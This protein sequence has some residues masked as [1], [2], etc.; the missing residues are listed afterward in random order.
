MQEDQI[1][2]ARWLSCSAVCNGIGPQ[3]HGHQL[4]RLL[5]AELEWDDD[6]NPLALLVFESE[7]GQPKAASAD[8]GCHLLLIRGNSAQAM[9]RAR[10][11]WKG[12]GSKRKISVYLGDEWKEFLGTPKE[13]FPMEPWCRYDHFPAMP[14]LIRSTEPSLGLPDLRGAWTLA[15]AHGP[16][17]RPRKINTSPC[18]QVPRSDQEQA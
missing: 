17:K 8:E 11:G 3:W 18:N 7:K 13:D 10:Q 14:I 1:P 16:L 9:A 6:E 15:L 2:G 12:F 4:A 5:V